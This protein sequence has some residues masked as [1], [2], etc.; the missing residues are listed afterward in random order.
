MVQNQGKFVC[1]QFIQKFQK[2]EGVGKPTLCPGDH[3]LIQLQ[4]S[5]AKKC[6]RISIFVKFW[7]KVDFFR[8]KAKNLVRRLFDKISNEDLTILT[9][10]LQSKSSFMMFTRVS[11]NQYFLSYQNILIAL[12][13]TPSNVEKKLVRRFKAFFYVKQFS[14]S[15]ILINELEATLGIPSERYSFQLQ[16]PSSIAQKY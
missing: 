14:F 10:F 6:T 7:F 2:Y 1:F 4:H 12:R 11:S 3:K 15:A 9:S 16:K 5:R 13:Q 8:K